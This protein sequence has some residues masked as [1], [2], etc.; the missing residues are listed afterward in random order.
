MNT[1]YLGVSLDGYI[2]DRQGGLEWLHSIPNPNHDDFGFADFMARVDAL[3]MGRNTFDTV[4]GFDCPWPY[5]K[6]VFV[7][8]R[9]LTSVPDHLSDRVQLIQGEPVQICNELKTLGY[10][11]LYI[12]GGVTIQRFLQAGL[13][14]ELILTQVPVLL[15]GGVPLFNELET[16]QQFELVGSEVLLNALVKSHYR[17]KQPP[18][19]TSTE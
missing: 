19:D 12:D 6:P 2:A 8:S 18:V 1:V 14:D 11:N 3:V 7:V 17:R 13:I 5:N 10:S 15:G 16:P 9:T 4:L